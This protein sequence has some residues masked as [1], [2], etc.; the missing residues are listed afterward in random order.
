MGKYKLAFLVSHP[1]QYMAPLFRL[2]SRQEDIDLT[3][4]YCSDHGV[5]P[6]V[7]RDFGSRV[8]W[9]VEVLEGYESVILKNHSPFDSVFA[10]PF[11]LINAGIA[12]FIRRGRFDALIVHGWHYLT[13]W[14]AFLASWSSGT[15]LFIRSEMPLNQELAKPF[16][17]IKLKGAVLSPLFNKA[18]GFFAIGEQ[19]HGFYTFYGADPG[20]IYEMP[21]AVDNEFFLRE[22]S[23]LD[24]KRIDELRSRMGIDPDDCVILFSGKLIDKKRPG[25]LL[26]AYGSISADN[27]ALIF[28]GDGA[29][30]QELED[31]AGKERLSKVFF[32]GFR[33]QTELAEFFT[34]SDVFVLP[35]GA[36][37]TWGLVVNEALCFGLPVVISDL[38]GSGY[39]LV[40]HDWN[41]YVYKTGDIDTLER[42][43]SELVA[44][45]AK[46]KRF[47]ENSLSRIIDWDFKADVSAIRAALNSL[48]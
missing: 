37:E 24:K 7:D 19:N 23:L 4:I 41:G 44:D 15:P 47:G 28:M 43:L 8:D 12:G 48:E 42:V 39:D 32:T 9:G 38:P 20:K 35:S 16:W 21:Y 11:G 45:P 46:R 29:L 10:V 6:S 27:K 40:R 26:K 33:Q 36:G 22:R 25:D 13:H 1:V 31:V 34:L 18:S 2:I 17:K 5:T 14:L 3:V 30:R